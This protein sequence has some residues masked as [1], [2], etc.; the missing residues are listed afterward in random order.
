MI[1]L[2]LLLLLLH[3][4]QDKIRQNKTREKKRSMETKCEEVVK[5][6][7]DE[8]SGEARTEEKIKGDRL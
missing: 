1:L 7:W 8:R 3:S 5:Y 4:R 2:L 6:R